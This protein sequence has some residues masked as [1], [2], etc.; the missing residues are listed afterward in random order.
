MDQKITRDKIKS[1]PRKQHFLPQEAYLRRFQ[2][3]DK[4]GQIYQ[5]RRESKK[6][7][8]T[9]LHNVGCERDLYTVKNEQGIPDYRVE[10]ELFQILDSDLI[11]LFNNLN[12]PLHAAQLT[13]I[14]TLTQAELINVATFVSYQLQRLPANINSM[15][16]TSNLMMKEIMKKI[17]AMDTDFVGTLK[18]LTKEEPEFQN[19][20]FDD[21]MCKAVRQNF[22]T[23][24]Y[25]IAK[26]DKYYTGVALDI[27]Y[28]I[29]PLFL[30][31]KVEIWQ[32]PPGKFFIT[33]DW[34]VIKIG[35]GGLIDAHVYFPIGSKTA[36]FFRTKKIPEPPKNWNRLVELKVKQISEDLI[37]A[38]NGKMIFNAEQVVLAGFLDTKILTIL[39]ST[40]KP[41]RL[42]MGK[43]PDGT[44]YAITSASPSKRSWALR[45][46]PSS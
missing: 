36:L 2:R 5:Y 20:E 43:L 14:L 32:A 21:E 31:K 27:A 46:N 28:K 40:T 10:T 18:K 29:I 4:P 1:S 24:D 33:S 12:S 3:P 19:E 15:E 39:H 35:S 23:G 42:S 22:L 26:G 9:G 41:K 30:M 44:P 6:I 37:E 45:K 25:E 17:T 34:P 7:F 16:D 8:P 13:S 38:L 11:P